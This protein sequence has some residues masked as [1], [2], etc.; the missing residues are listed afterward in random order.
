MA[1]IDTLTKH[2]A[3]IYVECFGGK[4][5]AVPNNEQLQ[6]LYELLPNIF[7]R[8]E[9][10]KCGKQAGMNPASVPYHINT[11]LNKGLIKRKETGLYEK[12]TPQG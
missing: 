3:G 9:F 1:I 10:V 4:K 6:R 7:T 11:F 8:P 5:L 12:C 2:A